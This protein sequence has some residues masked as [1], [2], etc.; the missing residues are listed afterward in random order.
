MI[1]N[2]QQWFDGSRRPNVGP[3]AAV[4]RGEGA[5]VIGLV[6]SDA[7]RPIPGGRDP[8]AWLARKLGMHAVTGPDPR[9]A[10]F[11]LAVLSAYP[12]RSSR[13]LLRP[14]DGGQVALLLA[15]LDVDGRPLRVAVT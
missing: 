7:T 5:T 8:V 13:V 9:E 6:E 12:I 15:T 3:V 1:W 10:T 14:S 4:V 11:G 2:L